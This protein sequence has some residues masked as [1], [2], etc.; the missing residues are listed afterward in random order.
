MMS[1]LRILS[2]LVLSIGAALVPS[3]GIAASGELQILHQFRADNSGAKPTWLARPAGIIYVVTTTAPN[4]NDDLSTITKINSTDGQYLGYAHAFTNEVPQGLFQASNGIVYGVTGSGGALGG[5]GVFSIDQAGTYAR[6][7]DFDPRVEGSGPTW[8]VEAGDG[9]FYGTTERGGTAPPDC[10]SHRAAGT[11]FHMTA[12]GHTKLLHTFCDS[13][14]GSKPGSLVLAADGFLYGTCSED[15]PLNGTNADG[16]GTFW[17]A[18]TKGRVR[19]LHVFGP[20]A[21]DSNEPAGPNGVMLAPD[22]FF[23]GT[24]KRGGG[25]GAGAIFRAN[26]RGNVDTIYPFDGTTGDAPKSIFVQ[27]AGGL[28]YG[29]AHGGGLPLSD[30]ER[31]GT[32]YRADASGNVWVLHT[33]SRDDGASP[34]APP[35]RD[36]DTGQIFVTALTGGSDSGL[37]VLGTFKAT[38]PHP[39][40]KVTIAPRTITSGGSTTGTVRLVKPAP[41]GG[42]VV[43]LAASMASVPASVTVPAGETTADF[44]IDTNATGFRFLST[45]TASVGSLGASTTLTLLPVE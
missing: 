30:T 37:G 13:I 36:D 44:P 15:G 33:F 9:S 21:P 17:R 28:F 3:S 25:F 8:L 29:T 12:G 22:G 16:D 24:S 32:V 35:L 14:D 10:A 38:G 41:V 43:Q 2:L 42:L 27:A 19:L 5:G 34:V 20:D 31:S 7:H 6:L 45:V 26:V 39:I 18:T 40:A 4:D 11:L 23:Y 1:I